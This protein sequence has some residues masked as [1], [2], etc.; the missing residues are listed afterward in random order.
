MHAA[1]EGLAAAD[2]GLG[3][4]D[5]DGAA[6]DDHA[7]VGVAADEFAG[8]GVEDG[9]G[10][11]DDH[12]GGDDGAFLD[13]GALIDA[14]VAADE[15]AVLDDR[16]HGA[17]G[18]EHAADLGRCADVDVLPHL[19]AGADGHVG[20]DH[21]AFAHVRAHI[22]IGRGHHDGTGGEVGAAA[23]AGSARDDPH[24]VL[25]LELAHREGGLVEERELA[26]GHVR[27]R[28]ELE[29]GED[30]FLHPLVDD[31]LAVLFLRDA[32]F[33]FFQAFD[34]FVETFE[35]Y[36]HNSSSV[37]AINSSVLGEA[38]TSG[39]RSSFLIRPRRAM[40]SLPGM[41]FGSTKQALNRGDSR[42]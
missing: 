13:D 25:G 33:A 20:I 23:D 11:G 41:G 2:D 1:L 37:L 30:H 34:D 15:R 27:D 29:P 28:A 42:W 40:A 16:G 14:A 31:P 5:D 22:D 32:D 24:A 4:G 39:R 17:G 35:G 6:G 36:F 8:R 9:G 7:A 26:L 21:R 12:A 3:A 19:R 38:G 10:G 18:L